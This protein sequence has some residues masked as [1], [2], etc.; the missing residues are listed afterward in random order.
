MKKLYNPS[1]FFDLQNRCKKYNEEIYVARNSK[2]D[3]IGD[4]GLL[5]GE[6]QASENEAELSYLD[7][8]IL[9]I[10]NELGEISAMITRYETILDHQ[11]NELETFFL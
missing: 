10:N 7:A 1:D 3:L 6:I 5:F 8:K 11:L 4:L 2:I 9:L